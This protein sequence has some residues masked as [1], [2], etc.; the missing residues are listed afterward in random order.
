M[1]C[2]L[3]CLYILRGRPH[4]S[5]CF[6]AKRNMDSVKDAPAYV[7]ELL[8]LPKEGKFLRT[9]VTHY[10][11]SAKL[12]LTFTTGQSLETSRENCGLYISKFHSKDYGYFI[13]HA[14]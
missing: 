5:P 2:E 10:N 12:E 6:L 13:A 9:V 3:L 7:P 11:C 14:Q 1:I 4:G 8:A